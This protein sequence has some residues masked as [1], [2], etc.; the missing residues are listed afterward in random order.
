MHL[1]QVF[2]IEIFDPGFN[3][4]VRNKSGQEREGEKGEEEG[5][6]D[7]WKA[8]SCQGSK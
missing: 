5:G 3:Q 6:E 7:N 4:E 2:Y 1:I 8:F